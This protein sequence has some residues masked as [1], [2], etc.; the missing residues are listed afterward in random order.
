M[1]STQVAK[2]GVLKTSLHE[3]LLGVPAT[4]TFFF[5]TK[6]ATGKPKSVDLPI[7]CW[8][9]Q[10]SSSRCVI[11]W[12]FWINCH[13]SLTWNK[14]NPMGM[15]LRIL[16]SFQW[17]MLTSECFIMLQACFKWWRSKHSLVGSFTCCSHLLICSDISPICA[18]ACGSLATDG[19]EHERNSEPVWDW[20][21]KKILLQNDVKRREVNRREPR[22]LVL[23]PPNLSKIKVSKSDISALTCA[24]SSALEDPPENM[25]LRNPSRTS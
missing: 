19:I 12:C 25:F 15:I 1:C 23:W 7:V 22:V 5:Q 16:S 13:I 10:I 2:P 18:V 21:V 4:K 8:V 3:A 17:L 20:C 24:C 14:A 6:S 9:H 11:A